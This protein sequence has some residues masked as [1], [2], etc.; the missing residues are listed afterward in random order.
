MRTS[1]PASAVEERRAAVRDFTRWW[2]AHPATGGLRA[3]LDAL[4]GD[5]DG[6]AL[7][8]AARPLLADVGWASDAIAVLARAAAA[9]PWF[10]PPWRALDHAKQRGLV[11][12]NDRRLRISAQAV[13]LE[14]L[15][16]YKASALGRRSVG[17]TGALTLFRVVRAAGAVLD[18][19]EADPAG[20]DFAAAHAGQCRP[21]RRLVLE[22]GMI[23]AIDGRREAWT[24]A[25]QHSDLV[26]LQAT[27]RLTDAPLAIEY[28]AETGAFLSAGAT[29]G[30]IARLQMMA[31]LLRLM[32]RTDAAPA[33][34]ALAEDGPFFL[35]WHMAREL[36]AIDRATAAPLLER[37]A[38]ADPHAE[39]RAAAGKT[40][41]L[42]A[43]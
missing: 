11:F 24:I 3:R 2:K 27:A 36:V 7:I 31:T 41:A 19:W 15:A 8:D 5:V 42:I 23:F 17:F 33:I 26:L 32:H 39:I 28:D 10:E 38:A 30:A 16:A 34:A 37:M 18:L 6:Q 20:Q 12:Y 43:A 4:S 40:L 29:D 35:R 25:R 13:P 9:D 1:G 21:G 22:D 14:S